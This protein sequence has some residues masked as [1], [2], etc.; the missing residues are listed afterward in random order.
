[1]SKQD[2]FDF[3]NIVI[4][5]IP[6]Q[7]PDGKE[8]ILREATG[9][10]AKKFNNARTGGIELKDGKPA[11]LHDVGDLEPL[12]VSLCLFGEPGARP[13]TQKF[14]ESWPARVV[15]KLY[16]KAREI[17]MLDASGA[18]PVKTAFER[19]LLLRDSPVEL[20]AM[21]EFI[22]GLPK[23]EDEWDPLRTLFADDDTAKNL[24]SSTQDG[25]ELPHTSEAAPS[26]S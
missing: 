20:S 21:T 23:D 6:V 22:K 19:A 9:A 15:T 5:E 13:V 4:Q 1:M 16:D 8:Y 26:P 10:A 25:S 2:A 12:L 14:V 11:G 7:G 3:S 18:N 17:S 24:P